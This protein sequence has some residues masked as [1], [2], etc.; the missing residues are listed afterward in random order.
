MIKKIN[1]YYSR[2]KKKAQEYIDNK[3]SVDM[4]FKSNK[5]L[6]ESSWAENS[7]SWSKSRQPKIDAIFE[8]G[9][10]EDFE[11]AVLE[12]S[13]IVV[14]VHTDIY[15]IQNN[16]ARTEPPYIT[17]A[18]IK[19]AKKIIFSLCDEYY[20]KAIAQ[21]GKLEERIDDNFNESINLKENLTKS[22]IQEIVNDIVDR[23]DSNLKDTDD[24]TTDIEFEISTTSEKEI[25]KIFSLLNDICSDKYIDYEIKDEQTYPEGKYYYATLSRKYPDDYYFDYE[26]KETIDV[27][28]PG[29]R[30]GKYKNNIN[31]KDENMRNI[32][33]EDL[34]KSTINF[35]C[36]VSI[37]EADRDNDY[38]GDHMDNLA[39][40]IEQGFGHNS[41]KINKISGY[42]LEFSK[43]T[44][45][46]GNISENNLTNFVDRII[47]I[48]RTYIP[49][50]NEFLYKKYKMS[51][52]LCTGVVLTVHY[53]VDGSLLKKSASSDLNGLLYKADMNKSNKFNPS[54]VNSNIPKISKMLKGVFESIDNNLKE[55]IKEETYYTLHQTDIDGNTYNKENYITKDD[56]RSALNTL[57]D[58]YTNYGSENVRGLLVTEGDDDKQVALY[59]SSNGMDWVKD[60]DFLNSEVDINDDFGD[61]DIVESMTTSDIT[62]H[63]IATLDEIISGFIDNMEDSHLD[64]ELKFFKSIASKLGVRDYN[65]LYVVVDDGEYDPD[66]VFQDGLRMP[67]KDGKKIIHFPKINMVAEY[68]NGLIFMYFV[69]EADAKLYLQTANE[70]LNPIELDENKN[71]F[72]EN[73]INADK[74]DSS[75]KL[76]RI[77][78]EFKW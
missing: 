1:Y 56:V 6:T 8:A 59:W 52:V 53:S 65:K 42:T 50:H 36:T 12:A 16:A 73:K 18:D 15:H 4:K 45:V 14:G 10:W 9:L 38:D 3:E 61:T 11:D 7:Y 13:D 39:H 22:E 74:I 48:I 27:I 47:Q 34:F 72:A 29:Q 75:I 30:T 37:C 26:D 69:T 25:N 67:S 68:N 35:D 54:D 77:D 20:E 40:Y 55:S 63:T 41:I 24:E 49:K 71:D 62:N 57:L 78:D 60:F 76:K 58:T 64:K 51:R 31:K 17:D 70:Y 19:E 43:K 2:V 28:K 46:K 23:M 66:F 44:P 32:L 33:K 21:N 5:K